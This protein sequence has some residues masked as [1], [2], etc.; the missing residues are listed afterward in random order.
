MAFYI[1]QNLKLILVDEVMNFIEESSLTKKLN[2]RKRVNKIKFKGNK[3][4]FSGVRVD[5]YFASIISDFIRNKL[6]DGSKSFS[7]E[8]VMSHIDKIDFIKKANKKGYKT[9][10]Y[11]VATESP[12]IN[13]SRIKYRVSQG[14]HN[15]A[16]EKVISRYNR[17]LDILIDM[18][19]ICWRSY[20]FDNSRK[21]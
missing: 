18:L 6:L 12:L 5:S 13:I 17:S 10:L 20:I 1:L 4:I 9:Y 21:N 11:Y 2:L 15:V 8:T 19:K 14:G 16:D 3:L 7:F